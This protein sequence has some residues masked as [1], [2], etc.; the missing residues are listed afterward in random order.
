MTIQELFFIGPQRSG[1]KRTR[2]L[3][4]NRLSNSH[5]TSLK[6]G[7]NQHVC[8]VLTKLIITFVTL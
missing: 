2:G 1:E 7:H 8:Y 5:P 4:L 3:H 6:I